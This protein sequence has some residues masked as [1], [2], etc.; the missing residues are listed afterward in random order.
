MKKIKLFVFMILGM[1]CVIQSCK[2]E[3]ENEQLKPTGIS[4]T[5]DHFFVKDASGNVISQFELGLL[6][7]IKKDLEKKNRPED[8][9]MLLKTYD[10]KTGSLKSQFVEEAI[11]FSKSSKIMSDQ[12]VYLNVCVNG[13][14]GGSY[15]STLASGF[16]TSG[17]G[18][19]HY[20][21]SG[22]T[23][24]ENRSILGFGIDVPGL[25]DS[26]YRLKY[27]VH[28]SNIG[29]EEYKTSPQ[30]TNI[31][32]GSQNVEAFRIKIV[33][34]SGFDVYNSGFS[35]FYQAHIQNQP[36][37]GD[38]DGWQYWTSNDGLAG[39]TGQNRRCEA[40]KVGVF[41]Y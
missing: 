2:S 14:F 13:G 30:L 12:Q 20:Y 31:T 41:S 29:W 21:Y 28:R 34:S 23:T 39:I 24:G 33:N 35:V 10:S 18:L 6:S 5:S 27:S 37:I 8:A 15:Y 11:K 4:A 40:M 1:S 17:P 38:G 7:A 19:N 16:A 22:G 9:N 36:N 3:L 32:D 25:N 26:G